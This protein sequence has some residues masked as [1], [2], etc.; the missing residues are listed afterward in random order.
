[1]RFANHVCQ[2]NNNQLLTISKRP[3]RPEEIVWLIKKG[4][5]KNVPLDIQRDIQQMSLRSAADFTAYDEGSPRHPSW[6]A[7]HAASGLYSLLQCE[8]TQGFTSHSE[9]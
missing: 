1:M 3:A 8:N 7:M 5:V 9:T 6:P 2:K 4:K